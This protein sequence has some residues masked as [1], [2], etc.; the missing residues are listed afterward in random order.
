MVIQRALAPITVG[1][2]FSSGYILTRA[3]DH[4]PLAY[5]VT[6]AS[7]ALTLWSGVHPL[8]VLA[9]AAV[10]GVTGVLG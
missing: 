7:V 8:A 4:T 3:S 9:A 2:M 1:L 10:V 5:A 6:A